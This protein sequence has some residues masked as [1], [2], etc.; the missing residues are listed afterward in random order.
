MNLLYIESGEAASIAVP[1]GCEV[2]VHYRG[3]DAFGLAVIDSTGQAGRQ[4]VRQ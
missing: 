3:F 2:Q 1:L 4:C